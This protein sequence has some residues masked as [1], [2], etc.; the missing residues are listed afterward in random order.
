VPILIYIIYLIEKGYDIDIKKQRST[1]RVGT[2]G[3]LSPYIGCTF[4][5]WVLKLKE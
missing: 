3:I 5:E 1:C 4:K 2:P